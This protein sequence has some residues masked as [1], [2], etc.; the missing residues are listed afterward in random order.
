MQRLI[1]RAIEDLH[2]EPKDAA[3]WFRQIANR[4]LDLIWNAE[5]PDRQIP[6]DWIEQWEQDNEWTLDL[7]T[8]P[9]SR[10]FQCDILRAMTNTRKGNSK[11]Y[12]RFVSKSN[13]LLVSHIQN[14]G[15]FGQHTD[16]QEVSLEVAVAFCLSAIELCDR[17][18][19]E[20]P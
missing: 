6:A 5:L 18:A 17:L 10:G 12:A 4:A 3:I 2:P 20:L 8:L 13:A 7:D 16:G 19:R 15:D 9:S 11:I 14:V 1:G